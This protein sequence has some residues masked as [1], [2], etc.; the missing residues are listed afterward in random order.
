MATT[1]K[2]TAPKQK[3]I[4]IGT[5]EQPRTELQKTTLR[6][7]AMIEALE[8]T[9]G[10]VSHACK[11][12]G[13]DR[14]IHYDWYKDDSEYKRQVDSVKD[15]VLDFAESALFKQIKE[16]NPTSTMYYLNNQGKS[17]GYNVKDEND[18]DDA[19]KFTVNIVRD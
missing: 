10:V 9:M 6:K 11:I 15:I 5:D 14:G 17:R 18:K 7:R 16:G 2:T 12:V 4:P 8:K 13:L 19:P 1:R 3:P